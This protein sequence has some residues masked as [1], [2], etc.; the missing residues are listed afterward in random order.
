V[1]QVYSEFAAVGSSELIG[2]EVG[3][4]DGGQHWVVLRT[5]DPVERSK[6][7][8]RLGLPLP[9]SLT[10]PKYAWSKSKRLVVSYD[11]GAS[12]DYVEPASSSA[13]KLLDR[14]GCVDSF[15]RQIEDEKHSRLESALWYIVGFAI[16]MLV[17]S[18]T[19]RWGLWLVKGSWKR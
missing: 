10:V 13:F 6:G 11:A 8:E 4:G 12:W 1:Q 17:V 3:T 14:Q 18:A 5:F 19:Y 15:V 7:P 9:P 2:L 16:L